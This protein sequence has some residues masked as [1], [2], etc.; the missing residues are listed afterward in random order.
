MPCLQL[1]SFGYFRACRALPDCVESLLHHLYLPPPPSQ[2][3]L[4]IASEQRQG[5]TKQIIKNTGTWL[6]EEEPVNT[7]H[8]EVPRALPTYNLF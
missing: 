4:G 1:S 6:A 2:S 3:P 5:P 7:G 8:S